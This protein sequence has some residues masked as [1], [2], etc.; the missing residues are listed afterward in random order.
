MPDKSKLMRALKKFKIINP[1]TGN[2]VEIPSALTSDDPKLRDLGKKKA[3]D[4][5]SKAKEKM[6]GGGIDKKLDKDGSVTVKGYEKDAGGY[7]DSNPM[8]APIQIAPQAKKSFTIDKPE[9]KKEKLP[10]EL[11]KV[12]DD[13]IEKANKMAQENPM[14]T[15]P[16]Q[17]AQGVFYPGQIQHYHQTGFDPQGEFAVDREKRGNYDEPKPDDEKPNPQGGREFNPNRLM[18][19]GK[20]RK[21]SKQYVKENKEEILKYVI[22]KIIKEELDAS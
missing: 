9:P 5:I 19:A 14:V 11:Q 8:R 20:S 1:R 16:I 7:D 12:K 4:I 10:P 6:K 22:K 3:K 18:R 21:E 15:S 13:A 2:K 17:T